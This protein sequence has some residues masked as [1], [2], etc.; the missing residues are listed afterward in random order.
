MTEIHSDNGSNFTSGERE[1][2]DAVLEWHQEKMHNS[3]MQKNIKW[4]FSPLYGSHFGAFGRGALEPF[5]K[6]FNLC[7]ESKSPMTK[8]WPH[9]CA[10]WIANP[11]QPCLVIPTISSHWHP[12]T[13]CCSNQKLLFPLAYSRK[14]IHFHVVDGDK[15]NILLIFSGGDGARNTFLFCSLDRSGWNLR[16]IWQ[17]TMLFWFRLKLCIA[18][19]TIMKSVP[20]ITRIGSRQSRN[21]Q[22]ALEKERFS[23]G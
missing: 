17:L 4:F 20:K 7:C 22:P 5:R 2:R 9:K 14:K 10:S 19:S 8:D 15:H 18:K 11:S 3:L 16:G 13:Y 23:G 1:L 12:T 6:S 21:R